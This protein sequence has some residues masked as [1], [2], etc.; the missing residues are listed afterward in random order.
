M[1][2]LLASPKSKLKSATHNKP[3]KEHASHR[4]RAGHLQGV[5]K[6]GQ[7]TKTLLLTACRLLSPGAIGEVCV[8]GPNVT[9]GYLN[10]PKANEEAFAGGA[11]RAAAE[12]AHR[13]A[14]TV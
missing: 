3:F 9:A 14:C 5:R 11:C 4:H 8:R 6:D 12:A 10:N 13:A 7:R 1:L 2:K